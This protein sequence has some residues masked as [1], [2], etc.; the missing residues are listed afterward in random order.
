MM[1]AASILKKVVLLLHIVIGAHTIAC[2][3]PLLLHH[4]HDVAGAW[5]RHATGIP[6]RARLNPSSNK[7]RLSALIR[8]KLSQMARRGIYS[9][10]MCVPNSATVALLPGPSESFPFKKAMIHALKG[11]ST[12]SEKVWKAERLTSSR[13]MLCER[14]RPHCRGKRLQLAQNPPRP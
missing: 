11:R 6:R 13:R 1:L 14:V 2:S 7:F 3:F 12:V 9:T 8:L 4:R 10:S 5:R